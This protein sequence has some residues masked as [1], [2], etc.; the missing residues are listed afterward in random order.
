MLLSVV[1]DCKDPYTVHRNK[2]MFRGQMVPHTT[3]NLCQ[4]HCLA[5]PH[6]FGIDWDKMPQTPVN[7]RCF[8]ILPP[9]LAAYGRQPRDSDCCD[10]YRKKSEC[11]QSEAEASVSSDDNDDSEAPASISS[12]GENEVKA[13]ILSSTENINSNSA[14]SES[15]DGRV[16]S[17]VDGK[18]AEESNLPVD[19]VPD[20]V[21]QRLPTTGNLVTINISF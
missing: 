13:S 21:Q 3:L 5:I 11:I 15:E 16:S 7:K 14:S 6:C 19:T 2:H 17:E 1:V 10:H 9:S 18:L 20:S 8:L 4:R 12:V